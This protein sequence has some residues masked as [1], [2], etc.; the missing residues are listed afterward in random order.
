MKFATGIA[1]AAPVCPVNTAL[2]ATGIGAEHAKAESLASAGVP[3]HVIGKPPC[4][5]DASD[6]ALAPSSQGQYAS[7]GVARVVM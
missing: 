1:P 5:P 6:V 2:L 4:T 7:G 3:V